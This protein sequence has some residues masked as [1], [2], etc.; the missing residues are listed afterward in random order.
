MT[1]LFPFDDHSIPLT[2]GLQFGLV[3]GQR[4]GVVIGPGGPGTPDCRK[5]RYYGTVIR[6]DDELRMWYFGLGDRDDVNR[7]CYAVSNDGVN[8]ER[9]ALGLVD[10]GGSKQNNLVD[11][12]VGDH[13]VIENPMI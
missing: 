7:V 4:K 1:I 6:I 8:W 9:P 10:Y 2:Y 3:Q 5:V 12:P 11:L 13:S